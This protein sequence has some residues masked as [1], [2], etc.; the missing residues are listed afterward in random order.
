MD[1][2]LP[3]FPSDFYMVIDTLD[4]AAKYYS[5]HKGI[6]EAFHFLQT[7]DLV[8]IQAGKHVIGDDI[9]AIVQEY[10]TTDAANEKMESHRQYIDVQY[11]I[12]GAELVGHAMM[13]GQP[14]AKEYDAEN[15]FMLYADAPS[16]YTKM[17]TGTFMI[18]FPTDPHMPCIKTGEPA[19]VKKVVVKV[20]V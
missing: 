18:F 10:E 11:M 3:C 6:K 15:D 16:F 4:N 14:I 17:E 20:K 9:F 5:L 7:T 8:A 12:G 2:I 19:W 1:F 13:K